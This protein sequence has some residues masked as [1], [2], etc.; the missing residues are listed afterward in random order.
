MLCLVVLHSLFD[1]GIMRVVCA[2]RK[3]VDVV[4]LS[5]LLSMLLLRLEN[6]AVRLVTVFCIYLLGLLTK[7]VASSHSYFH[8]VL[9]SYR[10]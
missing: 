4:L 5:L 2:V 8:A 6:C 10:R 1:V 3:D 7:L 9:I